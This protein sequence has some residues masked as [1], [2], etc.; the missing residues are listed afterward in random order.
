MLLLG[1]AT[2]G[3]FEYR[4]LELM[5]LAADRMATAIDHVQRFADSRQLVETLQRSLLPERLPRHPS[6]ELA[7]RYLPGGLAPQVGG[8]WYDAVE[9]GDSRTAVMIGDVVG[10]GVRAA[11]TMSELRNALRAFAIEGH[12]PADAL[13]RL[14]RVVHTTIGPGMIATA[15]FLVIDAEQGTVTV[16]RAG[17]PPPAL[18]L[19]DGSVRFLDTDKTLPVGIDHS[20]RPSEATYPIHPGE[21]LLLFTDG[22][23]ESRGEAITASFQRLLKAFAAAPDEVEAI[24]DHVLEGTVPTRGRSDDVAMLV[25]R[26]LERPVGAL[27]LKLPATADSVRQARHALRAWLSK[28]AAELDGV[29][30]SDLEVAWSEACT[31]VVRHAYG[32]AEASYDASARRED[33][34]IVLEVRDSGHWRAPAGGHGGRGL[35]LMRELCDEIEIERRD[36]GTA[37]VMRRL[38]PG[39]AAQ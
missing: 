21:T 23:I 5:R 12:G 11:T 38:L 30:C 37:V 36:D 32:P 33:G 15:L 31:N 20:R 14:D 24:C 10:H 4:H 17:H 28:N 18:R 9:L 16:A 35:P 29:A 25:V 7:A 13:Q 2:A 19:T 26:L 22:L 39:E 8:D 3:H 27:D 34:A 6:V 1:S